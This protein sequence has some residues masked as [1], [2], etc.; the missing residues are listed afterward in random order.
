MRIGV[1]T[2]LFQQ[3]AF[4][5]ALDKA[6]AAGV[7]AVEIGVGGYPGSQHCRVADLLAD[8]GERRRFM[9]AIESRG[10]LLSALSVHNNPLHP[11]PAV[12]QAAD[13]ELRNAIRLAAALGVPVVNGFSGLPAGAPGDQSPNWVTCPWPPDFL[14]ML[15]Y[16]WNEVAIPYWRDLE[17][18]AAGHNVQIAFEMHPGMLVYNVETLLRLRAATGPALGCNFDPSHLWWNGVEPAAAIRALGPAIFHVHGKDCFVDAHNVRVNGCNDHKPYD[19]ILE[20]AWTFRSIGYGHDAAEWRELLSTLRLVGYDYVISIEHEDA[21]M[22]TDEGLAKGIALLQ[23]V[24]MF[25]QPGEMF[26]A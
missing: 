20:R 16:Q 2:A 9:A 12:A 18:F 13:V 5:E 23:E 15:D 24:T 11:D 25:E 10:L 21:L 3:F 7:T 6:V 14:R 22:S 26:W 8:E 19:R 1:F 17:R 4:E